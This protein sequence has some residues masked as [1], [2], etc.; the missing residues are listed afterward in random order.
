MLHFIRERAQGWIAWF[1]VGLISIPFALWGVNSYLGGPTEVTVATVNDETITQSDYQRALQVQ[2]DQMRNM[3]GE[4]FDPSMFDSIQ[5]KRSVLDG[6]IDEKLLSAVSSELGQT[7]SDVQLAQIIQNTPAFLKDGKFDAEYYKA[8][9]ARAGLSSARYEYDLRSDMLNQEFVTNIQTSSIVTDSAIDNVIRLEKQS[10]EIAYGVVAAQ[11]FFDK[12]EVEKENIQ[13]YF[14]ANKQQYTAPEQVSVEYVELSV[15][16][17]KQAI[18]VDD[19]TLKTFYAD[20]EDQFI[21]PAQRR[22]SHIL[23][24]GDDDNALQTIEAL[25]AQIDSGESF[26]EIAETASQDPGSAENGGDLGFIA[27]GMMDE[28]FET[29]VFNLETVGDVT[30]PIK[31]EFGYH[32][33]KLTELQSGQ[34]KSFSEARDEVEALYKQLE[35]ETLFYE[36]AEQLAD[37]S[38]ESPD[39]L[40]LTAETLELEI[41]QSQL[42]TRTGGSGIASDAKVVNAAFSE[43]VLQ[44]DLNSAVIEVSKTDF[45]VLRKK[46]FVEETLLPFDSVSPA[47]E[48]S[49]RFEKARNKAQETGEGFV[50]QIEDGTEAAALFGESNWHE[51]QSYQRSSQNVSAQILEHAFA[52]AKPVDGI[53][54]Y[55]GFVA[56]NGNYIVVKVTAVEDGQALDIETSQREALL[57]YLK[58][59]A[60]E[61]ELQALL[62]SI[63]EEANI[64]IFEQHL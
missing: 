29:A 5:M 43:D 11:D 39:S 57:G 17:L 23:I 13:L 3:L 63:K 56:D 20:H 8:L 4:Q 51:A 31:T 61:S 54:N 21:G 40:D 58:R 44:N 47:I 6:L 14:E 32:L 18:D 59:M 16:V 55:S 34:G 45:I 37:L 30:A 41:K 60:T 12:V 50:A 9:L 25:K 24:E 62:A 52:V 10:R 49:L 15:D 19:A 28:A 53:A 22:V 35:A 27:K 38:Y 64:E 36:K 7:V 48:Q 33:I 46:R 42:F 1:I 2:R 26:E